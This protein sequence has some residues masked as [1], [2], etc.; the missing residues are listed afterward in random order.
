MK[1]DGLIQDTEWNRLVQYTGSQFDE[2]TL[3]R[4]FLYY[5]QGRV[6]RLEMPEPAVIHALV[7]GQGEEPYAVE[8]PVGTLS[9][10]SCSCPVDG[11]CKHMAAVLMKFAEEQGRSVNSLAN[12]K[13]KQLMASAKPAANS[14]VKPAGKSAPS[15]YEAP[16]GG[17]G[18]T[19]R[20]ASDREQAET[21]L[22]LDITEWHRRFGRL[23]A[24][25]EGEVK[26]AA[27]AAKALEVIFRAGRDFGQPVEQLYGLH[28]H[29]FVLQSLLQPVKVP[30]APASYSSHIGYF[31]HISA[32][33]TDKGVL[34]SLEDAPSPASMSGAEQEELKPLLRQ[35]LDWLRREMLRE[36]K[37]RYYFSHYYYRFWTEWLIP[38]FPEKE[39]LQDE[40]DELAELEQADKEAA[41]RTV[42]GAANPAPGVQPYMLRTAQAWI[43]ILLG[44]DQQARLL[45]DTAAAKPAGLLRQE[46]MSRLLDTV[47]QSRDGARLTAWLLEL[48]ALVRNS[49]GSQLEAYFRF[50]EAAAALDPAAETLMWRTMEDLLPA[51]QRF[52]ERKLFENGRWREWMDLQLSAG[53]E[54][55]DFK[56]KELQAIEKADPRLLLPFYHQAVER[57]IT[58][59]NRDSYKKAVK[60]LKRLSKLYAK[61]KQDERWALFLGVFAARH[62]RLRALQEEL[63]KGN[64]IS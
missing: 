54:P 63:R 3:S 13:A 24:P 46:D 37:E 60:L 22:S 45:L 17:G 12:A 1:S 62:S 57:Y 49:R 25:F 61:L 36:P 9:L 5:K 2:V 19:G 50:W 20:H 34:L 56:V 33:E 7:K 44:R 43:H 27:Y 39:L 15:L 31:T 29:L 42:T 35:S 6:L 58:H 10:A 32:A 55:L 53:A 26:N 47:Q 48:A 16:A 59:K 64:L 18:G 41:E 21:R 4:G 30:G 52:Y 14:A 8:I 23:T 38:F 28:A 40:L 51:A 11:P